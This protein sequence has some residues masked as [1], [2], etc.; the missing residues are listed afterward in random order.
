MAESSTDHGRSPPAKRPAAH[1][2]TRSVELFP[3]DDLRRLAAMTEDLLVIASL[4]GVLLA[5][6]PA[7]ERTLGYTPEES[8][9]RKFIEFVHP[10]DRAATISEMGRLAEGMPARHFVNR[11]QTRDGGVRWL[12]WNAVSDIESEV[13]Y[14]VARDITDLRLH[15]QRREK[16]EAEVAR[17]G[18][19]L[20]AIRHVQGLALAEAAAGP[21]FDFLLKQIL[22]IAKSDYGFIGEILHDP[23]GQPYLKTQAITNIAWNAE[24][25]AFYQANAPSGLEFRN[26]DNLF[27]EVIK[28]GKPVIANDPDSDPRSGGRPDGHPA[29]TAFLGLPL[30]DH[31]GDAGMLGIANRP[32]GYDEDLI[33]FV[34]PLLS[35]T[36]TLIR[37]YQARRARL[38]AEEEVRR[39][40]ERWRRSVDLAGHP[41]IVWSEERIV[42]Y[43]NQAVSDLLR[44]P[45]EKLIGADLDALLVE[46]DIDP[47]TAV[48][49]LRLDGWSHRISFLAD[50]DGERIPVEFHAVDLGDGTFQGTVF[51]MREW[52]E[53]EG[54]VREA[55]R[56]DNLTG[57]LNRKA[58]EE[59]AEVEVQRARRRATPFSLLMIDIDHFKR[60]NDGHGHLVG[61]A[62]LQRV[63]D[64]ITEST[65]P[66][67]WIGRWGGE[68]FLVVLPETDDSEAI[69]IAERI[70]STVFSGPMD[71]C[72][73]AP[74]PVTVSIGVATAAACVNLGLRMILE[75]ADQA[76]Y[77]AKERGRNR[78]ES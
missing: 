75:N 48:E 40:E 34:G 3:D 44:M 55:S 56:K 51:D 53:I 41:V 76:M 59:H 66:Y 20:E 5:F 71:I 57:L 68:E 50:A 54:K 70:R 6:N 37:T 21:V 78:V 61:D 30:S 72:Q 4:D 49:R 74:V 69:A 64:I 13:C 2:E 14:A 45:V 63:A 18:A 7:W 11:Y 22:V 15:E 46:D 67:D 1:P 32:G 39:S 28:T 52:V 35:T 25:R 26:L 60:I 33:D 19:V 24:T 73:T 38:D 58:L 62:A 10:D 65:R 16:A 47:D 77:R 36:T 42:T 29:M 9:H 31:A 17:T 43:V 12:N 27:G 23:D 8:L